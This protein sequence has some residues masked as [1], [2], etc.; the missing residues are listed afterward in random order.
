VYTVF[1]GANHRV[2]LELRDEEMAEG[3]A[4]LAN[5]EPKTA[6]GSVLLFSASEVCTRKRDTKGGITQKRAQ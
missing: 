6:S 1:V 2:L 5:G 4:G 3:I